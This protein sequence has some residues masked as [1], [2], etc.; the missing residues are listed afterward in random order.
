LDLDVFLSMASTAD[1][2][3]VLHVV[4]ATFAAVLSMVHLYD[5]SVIETGRRSAA[6][7]ALEFVPRHHCVMHHRHVL[8]F[9]EHFPSRIAERTTVQEVFAGR[10]FLVDVLSSGH[11]LVRENL[12][13]ANISIGFAD[14]EEATAR[15]HLRPG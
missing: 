2:F 12:V 8:A 15:A 9:E 5:A 14:R 13:L 6:V 4:A 7:H 11:R 1:R 3:E 10:Q